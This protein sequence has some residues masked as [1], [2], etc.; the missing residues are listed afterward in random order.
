[1]GTS[2]IDAV[3]AA[4]PRTAVNL[5]LDAGRRPAGPP[6]AFAGHLVRVADDD[7]RHFSPLAGRSPRGAGTRLSAVGR[8]CPIQSPGRLR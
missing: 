1:V 8:N 3:G 7:A 4:L 2:A 6:T 5:A